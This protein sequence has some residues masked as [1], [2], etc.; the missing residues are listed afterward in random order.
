M[1]GGNNKTSKTS[2]NSAVRNTPSASPTR[3]QKDYEYHMI[4]GKTGRPIFAK[5]KDKHET[6]APA[7]YRPEVFE[8]YQS[9]TRF[10]ESRRSIPKQ[11]R[12]IETAHFR[13]A[14]DKTIPNQPPR[15]NK[16]VCYA[17]LEKRFEP[18]P[19]YYEDSMMK[20]K[21]QVLHSIPSQDRNLLVN[22]QKSKSDAPGPQSYDLVT[23]LSMT[24]STKQIVPEHRIR[25]KQI[26]PQPSVQEFMEQQQMR[27]AGNA[28]AARPKQKSANDDLMKK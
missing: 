11:E 18:G 12:F 22:P 27:V 1:G 20:H 23:G 6:P 19:G 3:H 15:A 21:R 7:Y 13:F 24:S 9:K 5:D 16:Q 14:D 17:E 2:L 8:A 10:N 28:S 26:S 4:L 25:S